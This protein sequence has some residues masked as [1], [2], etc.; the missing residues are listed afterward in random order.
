MNIER[1]SLEVIVARSIKIGVMQT[2]TSLGML[3]EVVTV[4]KA[5]KIYG[6]KLIKDWRDKDWIKFYPTNNNDRG[7]YYVKRSELETARAMLDIHNKVPDNLLKQL[8]SY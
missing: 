5:E 2:L 8:M 7:K 3:P 4:S 6:R 1:N